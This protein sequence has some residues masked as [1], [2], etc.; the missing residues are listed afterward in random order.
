MPSDIAKPYIEFETK[1]LHIK[2]VT[3]EDRKEY[4]SLRVQNSKISS[5]Y[6]TMPG[7][8][9][10][11]WNGE[12]NSDDDIFFS[13][14]LKP[15]GTFV[16][17]AS[18]QDFRK[19]TIELGYDVCK[20]DQ[21][22]GI[23]TELLKQLYTE[24]HRFFYEAEI[25]IKINKD[26]VVSRRVAEKSGATFIRYDDSFISKR[27]GD[28]LDSSNNEDGTKLDKQY[29][30]LSKIAEEGKNSICIYQFTT[31]YEGCEQ[32]SDDY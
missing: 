1:R 11:E 29:S 12:L 30:R 32:F 7:F 16:A 10:M 2:P 23:A 24:A 9:D 18:I 3:E 26:N 15:E 25:I 21:N 28:I 6:A 13:V 27:I 20:E 8:E 31:V 14:R 19:H 22:Q 4:M 5:A 17:S